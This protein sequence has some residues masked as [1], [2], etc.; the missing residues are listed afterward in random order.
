MP[1]NDVCPICGA[2]VV[3]AEMSYKGVRVAI[4]RPEAELVAACAEHGRTQFN[5][6]TV[7]CLGSQSK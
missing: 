5:D 2:G 6:L 1:S 4:V 3:V 7:R